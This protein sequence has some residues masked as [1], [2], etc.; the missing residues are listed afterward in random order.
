MNYRFANG[1]V[2]LFFKREMK[3]FQSF[4]I[5]SRLLSF[6]SKWFYV[7]HQFVTFGG[8]KGKDSDGKPKE[9]VCAVGVSKQ[10]CWSASIFPLPMLY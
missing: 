3:P 4:Q 5:R 7:E 9:T 2:S 6:D 10:V 8:G 1:G